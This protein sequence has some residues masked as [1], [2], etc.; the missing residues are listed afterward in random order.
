MTPK[1][2]L[3]LGGAI[4][5][6]L[7]AKWAKPTVAFAAV[8]GVLVALANLAVDY[9]WSG[10]YRVLEWPAS[11]MGWAALTAVVVGGTVGLIATW[12]SI[13]LSIVAVGT[14][15]DAAFARITSK[16]KIS[17]TGP[18]SGAVAALSMLVLVGVFAVHVPPRTEGVGDADVT[19]GE[20]QDGRALLTI[21]VADSL[22][23]DAYWF[24]CMSWQGGEQIRSEAVRLAANEYQCE[25]PMPVAGDFKTLVR[26]Q[27]PV[28]TQVSAPVYMPADEAVPVEEYPA[29]S[30]PRP[31]MEERLI[32]QREAKTDVAAGLW[33][34]AYLVVALVF[35]GL[36]IA[37][38]AGYAVA[39]QPGSG[40][41]RP[42]LLRR[43]RE[44]TGAGQ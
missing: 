13:K 10:V 1:H 32:L 23:E 26:L 17:A 27:L 43:H 19:I 21:G 25:D 38:A 20:V 11:M 9:W 37:V 4:V 7:L 42:P 6:A 44:L 39:G 34:P 30:G 24:E 36:F 33:L 12:M 41:L 31:F 22:V 16:T 3:L 29:V 5:A 8:A 28:H 15:E 14:D 2:P 18:V 40:E 35:A